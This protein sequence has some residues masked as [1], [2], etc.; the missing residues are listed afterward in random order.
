[1]SQQ[2]HELSEDMRL[3]VH[4]IDDLQGGVVGIT[5]VEAIDRFMHRPASR[6]PSR[7]TRYPRLI[8]TSY[9]R[10]SMR[11]SEPDIIL[12]HIPSVRENSLPGYRASFVISSP[13]RR[14][15]L[16][17]RAWGQWLSDSTV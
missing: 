17:G 10:T 13:N 7:S 4:H 16:E 6:L 2:S 15:L 1:M 8:F 3:W 5:W 12:G 14:R 11:F 9:G